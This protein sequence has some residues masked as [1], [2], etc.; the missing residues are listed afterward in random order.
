MKISL[1]SVKWLLTSDLMNIF[2][3]SLVNYA[4]NDSNV[5]L[6]GLISYCMVIVSLTFMLVFENIL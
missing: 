1:F 4:A 3:Y 5:V 6:Q 2:L